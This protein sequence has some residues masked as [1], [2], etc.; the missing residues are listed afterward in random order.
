MRDLAR[1]PH[2]PWQ[3]R[4]TDPQPQLR[5]AILYHPP[6]FAQDPARADTTMAAHR[7]AL[8]CCGTQHRLRSVLIWHSSPQGLQFL[9]SDM[10][11]GA[12]IL[13]ARQRSLAISTAVSA[14]TPDGDRPL[15]SSGGRL[16]K[17]RLHGAGFPHEACVRLRAEG[18]GRQAPPTAEIVAIGV[19]GGSCAGAMLLSSR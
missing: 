19:G 11:G 17:G 12:R 13:R 8:C 3:Q 16:S 1:R 10:A 2:H 9:D 4:L 5:P 6:R 7:T 15:N 18:G 14:G